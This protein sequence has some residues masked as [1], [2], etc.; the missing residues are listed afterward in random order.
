MQQVLAH[1]TKA[2]PKLVLVMAKAIISVHVVDHV[3]EVTS[4]G[5]REKEVSYLS[6]SRYLLS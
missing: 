4:S 1:A 5:R 6:Y 2:N 3:D